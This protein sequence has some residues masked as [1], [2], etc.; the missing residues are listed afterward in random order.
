[1]LEIVRSRTACTCGDQQRALRRF[2]EAVLDEQVEIVPLVQDL[3]PNAGI[4]SH[5]AAG[6]AVLLGHE[7]LAQS[8]YLDVEVEVG[9]VEIRG[10]SLGCISVVIP[11]DLE[12]GGLVIP[13]DLIEVQ[14]LCELTLAVVCEGDTVVR[15][16]QM[17]SR[18]SRR[19]P[20]GQLP[21]LDSRRAVF[22]SV[23]EGTVEWPQFP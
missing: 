12:R 11:I 10:E 23:C 22:R 3:A 16:V 8:S 15:K 2:L 4:E 21:L 19:T 13:R 9:E 14:Q 6:L 1:V 20:L 17:G 5:Q 18:V 7:L